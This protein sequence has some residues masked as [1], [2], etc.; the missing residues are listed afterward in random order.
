M[1]MGPEKAV[2]FSLVMVISKLQ[3]W[4][5][6]HSESPVFSTVSRG[7]SFS[8]LRKRALAQALLLARFVSLSTALTSAQFVTNCL[9]WFAAITALTPIAVEPPGGRT[10]PGC[11]QRT[12]PGPS[13][14]QFQG[15]LGPKVEEAGAS[16]K[17]STTV[18]GP[19][20]VVL[21]ALTM[22]MTKVHT[23]SAVQA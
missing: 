2:S 22:S 20:K 11:S 23:P 13:F 19:E 3:G 15:G 5:V 12:V 10:M 18:S 17:L 1:R 6:R 4:P 7:R 16:A 8:G 9:S 21:P 14:T